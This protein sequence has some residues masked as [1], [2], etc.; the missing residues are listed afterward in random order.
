MFNEVEEFSQDRAAA[1]KWLNGLLYPVLILNYY[2]NPNE[3]FRAGSR[4]VIVLIQLVF[5]EQ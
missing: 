3:S 2:C 4:R 5:M 1:N